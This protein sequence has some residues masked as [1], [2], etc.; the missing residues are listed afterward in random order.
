LTTGLFTLP[1]PPSHADL[2]LSRDRTVVDQASF[3]AGPENALVRSLVRLVDGN[4]TLNG[5]TAGNPLTLYGPS[6]VGKSSLALALAERYRNRQQLDSVVITNGPDLAR[7]LADAVETDS[8]AE[9]R[10]RFHRCDLLLIDDLHRLANKSAAQQFLISALDSLLKRGSLVIVALPKPPQAIAGLVPP[11]VSRL[12][13]GLVVR[14]ALPGIEA[15]QEIIRQAATRANLCLEEQQIAT[16]ASSSNSST[17]RYLSAPKIRQ[18]VMQLAADKDL[19]RERKNDDAKTSPEHDLKQFKTL[20]RRVTLLVAKN[21]GLPVSELKSKSRRQ[22]IADARG[23]AMYLVRTVTPLSYADVGQLFGGR[24]HTTV[25]HACRKITS[26]LENDD[27]MRRIVEELT[28]E[29][30]AEGLI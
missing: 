25:M 4:L 19:G 18:L 26:Q 2:A 27:T 22:A 8:V 3:F 12:M 28:Q 10:A 20:S 14:L 1:L 7:S 9:H 30:G 24:D 21:F 16:L 23:L 5:L 29:I 13:G 6:G 11:L 17:D 15:R